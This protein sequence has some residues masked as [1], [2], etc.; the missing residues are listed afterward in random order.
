MLTERIIKATEPGP[1]P[2]IL[3][4]TE[5]KGFGVKVQPGG[6]KVFVLSYRVTGRKRQASIGRVGELALKEARK[7]AARE[8]AAIRDGEADPLDR[9]REARDAPT[10]AEGVE[11]FFREYAPRRIEDGRM[12]PATMATYRNQWERT[13]KSVPAFAALRIEVVTRAD[14]E[15]AIAPRAR[16]QRNRV[17]AFLNR[18]FNYFE[19]LE[20]RPQHSNPCRFVEKAREEARDRILS[21]AEMG[22]LAS[23][24]DSEAEACPAAV[25]AVRLAAVTGLRIGEVIAMQWR[26]VNMETGRTL[27]PETKT[28]RRWHDLPDAA[29]AVLDGLPRINAWCFTTGRNAP[30]TYKTAR[31]AFARACKAAGIDDCRLHDL[32]R[33]FATNAAAAGLSALQLQ[34]LLGWK[35]A[36]MPA[37]YVNLAGEATRESR[38]ALGAEIAAMMEAGG[39]KVIP[40][41]KAT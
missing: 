18:L 37:R 16:I 30:I 19:A 6:A 26:H 3:W 27:L 33:S 17:L 15:R 23:A 9:R 7:R 32:R 14:I 38:R 34:H 13:V 39:G 31:G 1:K 40:L 24:L 29:L 4:D 28:G 2:R 20:Y 36:T 8:L 22:A 21:P 10:V 35:Q 5:L 25:A 11:R 41:R 12:K